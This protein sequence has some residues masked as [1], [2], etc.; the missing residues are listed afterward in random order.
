M[1]DAKSLSCITHRHRR[2]RGV[3]PRPSLAYI[4]WQKDAVENG[5][6]P[7]GGLSFLIGTA[8]QR[9]LQPAASTCSIQH[10]SLVTF[11]VNRWID[12]FTQPAKK[13]VLLNRR[14]SFA[15]TSILVASD[16]ERMSTCV[17]ATRKLF[18]S[19]NRRG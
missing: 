13:V 1:V 7:R 17:P 15:N 6:S 18:Y 9:I 11:N 14:L 8:L 19:S 4:S 3:I 2:G 10:F 16:D 5:G 12:A